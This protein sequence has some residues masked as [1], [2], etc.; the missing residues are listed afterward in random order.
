MKATFSAASFV[1][2]VFAVASFAAA[3]AMGRRASPMRATALGYYPSYGYGYHS[4]TFE[5]GVLRGY[6][7][8]TVAQGQANYLNSL[9]S[10]N[11]QEAY[12][13]YLQNRQRTTDT[14]F[15]MRQANRAAREAEAPQRLSREQYAALAKKSAPEGLSERQYD[16]TL[17]RLNWPAALAGDE[18]A[19]ERDGS[20]PRSASLGGRRG[21]RFSLLRPG[22]AAHFVNRQQAEG[23]QPRT[24][25][26]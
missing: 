15:Y 21:R 6:A 22:Q 13:R 17:G 7:D 24:D 2:V 23:Q 4:S 25:R 20:T 18:F 8:L 26:R 3:R 14:Y 1:T 12:S 9:A 5:E 11:G 10:I 16:R 19:G